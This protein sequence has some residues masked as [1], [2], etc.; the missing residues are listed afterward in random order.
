MKVAVVAAAAA[1]AMTILPQTQKVHITRMA[2]DFLSK[3]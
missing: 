1:A 2:D 3:L